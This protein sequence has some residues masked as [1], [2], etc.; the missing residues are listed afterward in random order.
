[1]PTALP[2]D[3]MTTAEKLQTMEEIWDDLC[4][5]P[6]SLPSPPWHGVVLD[7]REERVRAGTAEFTDWS[8]AKQEFRDS[9]P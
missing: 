6:G 4:R 1:M 3:R 8:K 5:N 7:A 9:A 2:L